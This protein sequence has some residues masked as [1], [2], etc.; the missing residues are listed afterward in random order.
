MRRGGGMRGSLGGGVRLG[1]H[2]RGF[3]TNHRHHMRYSRGYTRGYYGSR[4]SGGSGGLIMLGIF[5]FIFIGAST[6]VLGLLVLMF[7]IGIIAYAVRENKKSSFSSSRNRNYKSKSS[8]KQTLDTQY[9]QR[10]SPKFCPGC[11]SGILLNSEF[12][13]ECGI[14]VS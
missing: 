9:Y 6:G 11:G 10:P 4:H 2:S 3:R 7:V 14:K 5:F 13:T 12:C 8:Q 1:G